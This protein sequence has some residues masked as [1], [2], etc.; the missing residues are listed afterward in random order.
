MWPFFRIQ[1]RIRIRP[2]HQNAQLC[3]I[4]LYL[5]ADSTVLCESL[6][7]NQTPSPLCPPAPGGRGSDYRCLLPKLLIFLHFIPLYL[8]LLPSGF[9]WLFLSLSMFIC[10]CVCVSRFR[11]LF[12]IVFLSVSISL[13]FSLCRLPCIAPWSCSGWRAAPP[14]TSRT[15]SGWTLC[16]CHCI[17]LGTIAAG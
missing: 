8:S 2:K 14:T 16:T 1:I 3:L 17:Q 6:A 5:P 12:L 11:S 10:V 7:G 15:G 4:A 9:L 13:F